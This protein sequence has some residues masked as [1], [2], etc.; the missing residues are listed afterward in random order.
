MLDDLYLHPLSLPLRPNLE[1]YKKLAKELKHAC[2][3]ADP[4]TIHL[5]VERSKETITHSYGVEATSQVRNEIEARAE[6]IEQRW[7]EFKKSNEHAGRC[8]LAGAQLFLARAH[9]FASWPKFASHVEELALETTPVTYF[10][11]AADAIVSGDAAKL[12]SLLRENPELV[13]MR[14][15][16]RSMRQGSPATW[17]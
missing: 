4:G 9:G 11:T 2:K 17:T 6:R 13:R 16:R 15:T 1:Q 7:H 12:R 8:T 14:S 10:E 3:S 5:W